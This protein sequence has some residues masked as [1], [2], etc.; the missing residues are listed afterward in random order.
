MSIPKK[1][2]NLGPRPKAAVAPPERA[3][4]P[5]A[6]SVADSFVTPTYTMLT[7]RINKDVHL[8]FKSAVAAQGE[9]MRDIVEQLLEDWTREHTG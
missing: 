4:A 9:K 6:P 7:V 8:S 1:R 5:A 2:S 3:E